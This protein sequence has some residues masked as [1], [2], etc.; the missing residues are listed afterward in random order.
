M[1]GQYKCDDPPVACI[2]LKRAVNNY[3]FVSIQEVLT[4]FVSNR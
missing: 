1:G 2:L 3:L 4:K